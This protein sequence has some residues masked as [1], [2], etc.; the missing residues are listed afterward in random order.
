MIKEILLGLLIGLGKIIPGVSGAMIAI[1]FGIY[2]KLIN[3]ILKPFENIKFIITIGIGFLLA[4]VFGSKAIIYFM[5]NYYYLTMIFFIGLISG[6]IPKVINKAYNKNFSMKHFIVTLITFSLVITLSFFKK[7]SYIESDINY[8][9]LVVIGFIE[10]LTMI[11]PG[12]SGTAVLMIIGYYD[13]VMNFF[14]NILNVSYI[15]YTI[16]FAIP[17]GIGIIIGVYL[18]SK[19]IHY[20]LNKYESLFFASITGFSI[21]A[22]LIMFQEAFINSIS[23]ITFIESLLLITIGFIISHKFDK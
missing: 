9:F 18:V 5:D 16:K 20:L 22:I 15:S 1:S 3:S 4:I 23:L 2:D 7:Q 17:F 11:I 12:I 13:V 19:L 21:S 10:A 6:G 14:N 8:L